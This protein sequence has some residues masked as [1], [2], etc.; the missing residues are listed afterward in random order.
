MYSQGEK[1]KSKT[2][3]FILLIWEQQEQ[4]SST[5]DNKPGTKD[6][7]NTEGALTH[8]GMFSEGLNRAGSHGD[9]NRVYL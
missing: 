1:N 2:E 6:D 4:S 5:R 3:S 9:N 7:H 8:Q